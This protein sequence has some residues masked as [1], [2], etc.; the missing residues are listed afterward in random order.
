MATDYQNAERRI[1]TLEARLAH[2]TA[3][4]E[5]SVDFAIIATDLDGIITD[6]NTG[7]EYLFGWAPDEIVGHPAELFFTP[8]DNVCDRVETE[9]DQSLEHGRANDER[10]HMRKDGSRFW[11]SGE[12]M[13]L[14]NAAGEAIGFIKIVRDRTREHEA[15]LALDEAEGSLRRAQDVGGVGVFTVDMDGMMR[16]T[17]EFCRIFGI[18][19][20]ERM[21]ATQLE[22]L[23]IPEDS[24]LASNDA[25]RNDGSAAM[26]A[27]YRIRR[28]DTGMLRWIAR[29]GEIERHENGKPAR[30]VGTVRDITEERRSRELLEASEQQAQEFLSEREFIIHLTA[31][32]RAQT[33]PDAVFRMSSEALG[34][35]LG[36]SR[37]GFYRLASPNTVFYNIGWTDGALRPLYGSRPTDEFGARVEQ[38]R[39]SGQMLV[40]SDSRNDNI[41]GLEAFAESSVL[42]GICLSLYDQ[43]NWRGGF[44][45]HHASVRAWLATEIALAREVAELTWLAVERTEAVIRMEGR[46]GQ[47]NDA[48]GRVATELREQTDGRSAAEGQV[49]QLQKMEAVGQL[50]GG[51][52]HDFNNMLAVVI[53]GVNLAQR[54]LARGDT[55][56]SKFLD[57]ALDG[58][59]RAANLTQRLLAF[60]RQSP[61]SPE[62]IDSNKMVSGLS[63]LL[64]RTLGEGVELEAIL[65]AGLWKTKVDP[66]GLENV[67]VNLSV[68]A[69][70]AMPDGGK[71]T[72]ETANAHVDAAY[73]Q[74]YEIDVGQ[75]VLLSVSDTGT[76]MTPE[77][78]VKAFDPFFTTK[79][80]GK[81]TGLGLSQVFGFVRQSGGHIKAYSE[82][83][84]GT[85]FKIYLPRSY[86]DEPAAKRRRSKEL[87]REGN[88]TEVIL[89]VEDEDRVRDFSVEALRE[90]GYT[91]VHARN[92]PEALALIEAGQAVTLLFTDIVMPDMTGRQL[93]DRMAKLLPETK[94]VYT[95]GYTRNAVVHNGVLDP[96]THFLPKPFAFDQLAGII[97]RALD[98][99][100]E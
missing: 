51:I 73:A 97:R 60:S 46:I 67:I 87:V 72:I 8:E 30:Y 43:G 86:S 64:D 39:R 84:H 41:G 2:K 95:T 94:V 93:A 81:G 65:G 18:P 24:H 29:R 49:R 48:L 100:Q 54:R 28:A 12:M 74:D 99:E 71:L 3:I 9:M 25:S 6:W 96:G 5:S 27:V 58:A 13:P 4:L 37:V 14:T 34:K 17:P 22:S 7:A 77:I 80:V 33:D 40:F 90:L 35:R 45:L 10:W 82:V 61:L 56:V 1:A 50:T 26:D 21:P 42:S 66:N 23:I 15:R 31:E 69:R 11:A 57:G 47:Q 32:Q 78:M 75:Y 53:G 79:G 62:N 59:T 88:P 63:D 20:A 44:Y 16:A 76:G 55:D 92:G 89:V 98:E 36:V 52:A 38:Q 19:E 85:T 70:D 83:G 91:V 68:N